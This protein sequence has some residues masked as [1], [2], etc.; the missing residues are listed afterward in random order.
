MFVSSG[1]SFYDCKIILQNLKMNLTE[2]LNGSVKNSPMSWTRMY[3]SRENCGQ[4]KVS[5]QP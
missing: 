5:A 2:V 3:L 4:N 1:Y